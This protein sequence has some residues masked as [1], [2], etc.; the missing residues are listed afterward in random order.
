MTN[1]PKNKAQGAQ[2][3]LA[4]LAIAATGLLWI[5][6]TWAGGHWGWPQHIRALFD[7][8]ALAG[9]AFALIVTFRIWRQRQKNE[10]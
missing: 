4:S 9:F 7:L 3:R 2:G 10:G 8:L 6:A 5:G 1:D